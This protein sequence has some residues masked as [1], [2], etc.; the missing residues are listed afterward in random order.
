MNKTNITAGFLLIGILTASSM[1]P[2]ATIRVEKWGANT[3]DC[4]A[5]DTP[6]ADI[7]HAIEERSSPNDRILVGPGHY[8]EAVVIN[9]NSSGI[10]LT[11]LKLEST[12]GMHTTVIRTTLANTH[13]IAVHQ[14]RVR[15]G[16]R[17]RGFTVGGAVSPGFAAIEVFAGADRVRIEGNRA[18][19]SDYGMIVRGEKSQVRYNVAES[20]NNLGFQC[21]DCNGGIIRLNQARGNGDHGFQVSGSSGFSFDRNVLAYNMGGGAVVESNSD[22]YKLRDNVGEFNDSSGFAIAETDGSQ[23]LG[24][25]ALLNHDLGFIL[26]QSAY[27]KPPLIRNNAAIYN[28]SVGIAAGN[29]V[30]ARLDQNVALDNATGIQF[31]AASSYASIT[32]NNTWGSASGCGIENNSGGPMEYQRHFFGAAGVLDTVCGGILPTGT[33]AN[34]PNAFRANKAAKL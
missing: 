27:N 25:I 11:G 30:G 15:I 19:L 14:P 4:G 20:N 22:S 18:I 5:K 2:A 26:N 7:Q 13:G 6:C 34:R 31:V 1:V 28:D 8:E 3:P 32:G 33:E 9:N 10:A 21:I 23:V 17:G 29:L 12:S 16:K 24:N